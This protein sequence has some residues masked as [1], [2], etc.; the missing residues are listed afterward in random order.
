MKKKGLKSL[1]VALACTMA[2][3]VVPP[4]ADLAGTPAFAITAEA[5]KANKKLG[6]TASGKTAY[7]GKGM[8]LN[9]KATNNAKLTYSSSNKKI[10]TVNGK[11][12]ITG[13]KT[14]TVKIT[15]TAKKSGYKTAKK[16]VTV[17]IV[18]QGQSIAASNRSLLVGKTVNLNAKAKTGL[19]YKSSNTK[20]V[21]VDKKGNVKAVSAGTAKITITAAANGTYN[22]TT[23]TVTVRV[24]KS[25]QSI[26]AADLNLTSGQSKN[27]GAKAKTGLSY[28]S[29]NT[30]VVT[31]DKNGNVKAV[32]A[33]TAKITITASANGTYNKAS[34]TITVKVAQPPK[35][36]EPTQTEPTQ[37][38]PAQTEPKQ[39]E[40]AQTEP[41][42]TE[43]AQTEPKQTEPAQTE[44]AQTEPAQTE[45]RQTEPAQTEPAQ[46]EP[47][48]TEPTQTEAPKPAVSY[49]TEMHFNETSK[50]NTIYVGEP[51]ASTL[52][53]T[54]T[55]NTTLRDFVFTSSDPSIATV[56]ENGT[57]TGLRAGNVKITAKSKT[58]FSAYGSASNCL[59]VTQN[60]KIKVKTTEI[61]SMYYPVVSGE[62]AIT[63]KNI[64]IGETKACTLR[65]STMGNG[66]VADVDFTTSDPSIATV[67]KNGN[68]TGL[69]KGY[70]TITAKTK[71][72]SEMDGVT[73]LTDSTTYHVGEYTYE[74]ILNG[75]TMDTA[76]GW[77]AHE[78]MNDLRKNPS[79]RN[80][81]KDY[82]SYPEREWSDSLLRDAA[83]RASRN[84][85]CSI[86]GGWANGEMSTRNPLASHGGAF[87]GY[88]GA[89]WESTGAELGK[90]ASVFF[91][92]AGHF[93]NETDPY[94]KYEAVAVVQYK[95]AAG[96]N[97][98]S[99]IVQAS[100]NK[101]HYIENALEITEMPRNQYY[102]YCNHFGIPT[103][104]PESSIETES[105]DESA[106][107]IEDSTEAV[108]I[109]EDTIIQEEDTET[110]LEFVIDEETDDTEV[111]ET[112]AD[113]EVI[114]EEEEEILE[115]E[116]PEEEIL[117]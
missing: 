16:V 106:F 74:E 87:N 9:A 62:E 66:S 33:G 3:G 35:Q 111:G 47:T 79:H 98:T 57:I 71:L 63:E 115:T 32:S 114:P 99:M 27:L 67:D 72:P 83:T 37:T 76:A 23:R 14:G 93:G 69:S 34:R 54:A 89:G 13:K 4:S 84:I 64:L 7:I 104:D 75:L 21:T 78:T 88:G 56:D 81:F 36:T 95:N 80:F 61:D 53:W 40:P 6:I 8:S 48:Q 26:T 39:T 92:D 117:E 97:L 68:V 91:E 45:P 105:M 24:N 28:K 19:S 2:L 22:K 109:P 17:K 103:T 101:I 31:V 29:S 11:G 65:I 59:S 51:K 112:D 50:S 15:I 96:V 20:I 90:A 10:A 38:E 110:N 70:V 46:T 102:D 43:P 86:L 49:V 12:V 1:T 18:K 41:K 107:A 73:I 25:N 5:A 44:P 58:P 42:Q 85:V 77:S 60:Y 52:K 55:G 116:I 82:P 108:E 113:A 30:K 94:H 100:P